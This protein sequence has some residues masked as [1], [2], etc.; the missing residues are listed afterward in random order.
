M[1]INY[2]SLE[3]KIARCVNDEVIKQRNRIII[4]N[5]PI[6]GGIKIMDKD[7]EK[8]FAIILKKFKENENEERY[9]KGNLNEFPKYFQN[10]FKAIFDKLSEYGVIY[11]SNIYIGGTWYTY[12]TSQGLTYFE[13]KEKALKKAEEDSVKFITYNYNCSNNSGNLLAGDTNHS[14]L[15]QN[16]QYLTKNDNWILKL[17]N[18]I[19][20]LVLF[21]L[22]K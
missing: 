15:S 9:V 5:Q 19:K 21:I 12:I 7:S 1:K 3:K 6:I 11:N 16:I 17:W 18:F 22:Q 8:L 10:T 2:K 4:N 13:D 14:S 20:K